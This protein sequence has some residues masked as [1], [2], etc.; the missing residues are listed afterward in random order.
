LRA[1]GDDLA[2]TRRFNTTDRVA[3]DQSRTPNTAFQPDRFAREI[4][5]F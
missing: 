5:V 3:N 2:I 4:V 1:T